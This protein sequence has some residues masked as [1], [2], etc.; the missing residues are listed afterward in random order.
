[1]GG[2][3]R[4]GL[5]RVRL[6]IPKQVNRAPANEAL[7]WDS[8]RVSL[9]S[10]RLAGAAC[11]ILTLSAV[12]PVSAWTFQHGHAWGGTEYDRASAIELDAAGNVYLA[13]T[14]GDEFYTPKHAFVAKFDPAGRL[15]WDRFLTPV[16]P[17]DAADA[18]DATLAADGTLLIT[19]EMYDH[20]V[21]EATTF[22][23]A[24]S[25]A[26]DL[27][28][29]RVIPDFRTPTRIQTDPAS[30]G[31]VLIGKNADKLGAIVA[32]DSSGAVRWG[33]TA[34]VA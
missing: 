10:L 2:R 32:L 12:I 31:A 13:G 33:L 17:V 19:G 34:Q 6:T 5:S 1:M 26:G 18:L 8:W 24:F 25:P 4:G 27:L 3:S 20:D 11:L 22:V 30:G 28:Y 14:A 23:A 29:A 16:P 15:L 7:E 21:G 9:S